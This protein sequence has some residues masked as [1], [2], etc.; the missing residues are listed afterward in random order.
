MEGR[1]HRRVFC[2][3]KKEGDVHECLFGMGG[4]GLWAAGL[5]EESVPQE[6]AG[7]ASLGHCRVDSTLVEG[8]WGLKEVLARAQSVLSLCRC[9]KPGYST[10]GFGVSCTQG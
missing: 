2:W 7:N 1:D 4:A 6:A 3:G 8:F 9:F 5:K 10:T